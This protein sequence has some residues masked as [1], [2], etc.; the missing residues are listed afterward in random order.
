MFYK[1]AKHVFLG[2]LKDPINLDVLDTLFKL[3][4]WVIWLK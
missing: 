2:N 1:Q 3:T 4:V